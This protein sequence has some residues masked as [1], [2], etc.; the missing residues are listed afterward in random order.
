MTLYLLVEQFAPSIRTLQEVGII[1]INDA[2]KAWN[3]NH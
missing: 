2:H 1:N 3:S